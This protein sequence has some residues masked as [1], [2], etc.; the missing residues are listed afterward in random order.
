MITQLHTEVAAAVAP[1]WP[2][3]GAADRTCRDGAAATAAAA[4]VCFSMI[5][6]TYIYIHLYYI[7]AKKLTFFYLN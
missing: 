2:G 7:V 4:A 6:D 3:R 5:L 1:G